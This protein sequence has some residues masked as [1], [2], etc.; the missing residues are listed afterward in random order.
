MPQFM[1][2]CWLTFYIDFL[3]ILLEVNAS[4]IKLFSMVL[5]IPDLVNKP[6]DFYFFFS[7]F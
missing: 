1:R 4:N 6:E 3:N 2:L 5:F 7:I